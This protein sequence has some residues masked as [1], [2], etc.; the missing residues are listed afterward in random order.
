MNDALTSLRFLIV[1]NSNVTKLITTHKMLLL[2]HLD[3]SSNRIERLERNSSRLASSLREIDLMNNR[4]VFIEEDFFESVTALSFLD[5]SGNLLRTLGLHFNLVASKLDTNIYLS[6]NPIRNKRSGQTELQIVGNGKKFG[7]YVQLSNTSLSRLP[8]FVM[9]DLAWLHF[10]I[11][12]DTPTIESRLVHIF[13]NITALEQSDDVITSIRMENMSEALNETTFKQDLVRD[14]GRHT[15][16]LSLDNNGFT[17]IPDL[18]QIKQLRTLSLRENKID[19]LV[20]N[21]MDPLLPNTI[22]HLDLSHNRIR[23]ISEDFF[24]MFTR[25][26]SLY[27]NANELMSTVKL[28]FSST[29]IERISLAHNQIDFVEMKFPRKKNW[30]MLIELMDLSSN[31]IK[32]LPTLKGIDGSISNRINYA[33]I[34]SIAKLCLSLNLVFG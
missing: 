17:T 15:Q 27:L 10:D 29:E 11:E 19:R 7:V 18:C 22:Q 31:K 4:I 30:S 1:T 26:N 13:T 3:F 9:R 12:L 20:T 14:F 8:H 5:L 34:I 23:I 24:L 16:G 32:L 28:T 21:S 2:R 6:D 33:L 25:L